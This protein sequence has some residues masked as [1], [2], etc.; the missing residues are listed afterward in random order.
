MSIQVELYYSPYCRRCS[1]SRSAVRALATAT[2]GVQFSELNV[3]DH[4]ET[5]AAR[6]VR[7]TPSIAING[8]VVM[9]GAVSV[10]RLR[11]RLRSEASHVHDQ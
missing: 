9:S 1:A 3:L 8:K 4:I 6:G 7:I 2:P 10:R 5:A 11:D